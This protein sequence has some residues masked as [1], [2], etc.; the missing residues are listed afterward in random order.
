MAEQEKAKKAEA[1]PYRYIDDIT[2]PNMYH[3][4]FFRASVDRGIVLSL[5]LPEDPPEGLVTVFPGD[6]PGGNHIRVFSE[7]VPVFAANEILYKGQPLFLMAAAKQETL[8]DFEKGVTLDIETLP[9]LGFENFT[10]EQITGERVL[11]R[12]NPEKA[13]GESDVVVEETYET[14]SQIHNTSDPQGAVAFPEGEEIIVYSSTQW[15]FHV[16]DS[17]AAAL[18]I[19]RKS[20]VVRV[21]DMSVPLDAKIWF[22]SVLAVSAAAAARK[23]G[24]PVRLVLSREEAIRFGLKRSPVIFRQKTA[25]T[26]DG[27]PHVQDI[28][29]FVNAGA[30][31]VLSGQILDRITTGAAGVYACRNV[32]IH[33]RIIRTSSPPMGAFAGLGLASAFFAAELQA[34]RVIETA[35]RDPLE[36]KLKNILKKGNALVTGGVLK[37]ATPGEVLLKRITAKSDFTRKWAAF[38]SVSERTGPEGNSV[39]T[40]SRG[41]GLSVCFQGNGMLGKGEVSETFS[42]GITMDKNGEVTVLTSGVSGRRDIFAVWKQ[43]VASSMNIDEELVSVHPVDTSVV[44]DSGPSILSRNITIITKLIERCCVAVRKQ[45]FRKPL[46]IEVR[47]SYSLPGSMSWNEETFS[48][49]PFPSLSWAACVVELETAVP[50]DAG[51]PEIH[52]RGIWFTVDCGALLMRERAKGSIEA[53]IY[54][55]LEWVRAPGLMG[56][57]R[58]PEGDNPTAI[59]LSHPS[60]LP[61]MDIEFLPGGKQSSPGGVGELPFNCVPAAYTLALSQALGRQ[62]SVLPELR[63]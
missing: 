34:A 54:Q 4:R 6:L 51:S 47:R 57:Y 24:K 37:A 36:W 45:R 44:P 59:C 12:G 9:A 3:A 38:R 63:S 8:D 58:L 26:K 18:K 21:P 5:S 41:I 55:A 17:V 22:P 10:E 23:S 20:V 48:G 27:N 28:E 2:A 39:L 7:A 56:F 25:L 52:I 49:F 50:Y 32:R 1:Y 46:P 31:P 35:N 53:G 62:V 61:L 15:P 43:L 29:V 33:G 14:G 19:P 16:R 11:I 60:Y 13:L 42:A 40:P 30:F